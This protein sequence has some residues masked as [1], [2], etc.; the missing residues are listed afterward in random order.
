MPRPITFLP[1]RFEELES[2]HLLSLGPTALEQELLED[3]NRVRA[4]PQAELNYLFSSFDP[5]TAS[6]STVQRAIDYFDVHRST[7]LNQW[8]EL[9]P[10]PPLAWNSSLKLSALGHNEAMIGHD[11]QSH[12]VPGELGV[13]ERVEQTGYPLRSVAENVYAF[14]RSVAHAH[15]AFAIDWGDTATGIQSPP[16]HRLNM[17]SDRFQE[18]G[19]SI[20]S[21]RD[22]QTSLGPLIVT[23][24]FGARDDYRAQ[25]LGVVFDDRNQNGRYDAREGLPNVSV[26]VIGEGRVYQA[27][28]TTSGGYQLP[29]EPGR[30]TVSASGGGLGRTLSKTDVDVRGENVKVDFDR[31]TRLP[32]DSNGDG[33]FSFQDVIT[34]LQ[35][36]K[37]LTNLSAG[38]AEGD[39]NQ[40]GIFDQ[41]DV[42]VLLTAEYANRSLE[43]IPATSESENLAQDSTT[44]EMPV[45]SSISEVMVL[46]LQSG[47]YLTN[48]FATA[49]E[50]DANQDGRFDQRDLSI[51][52]QGIETVPLPT[53]STSKTAEITPPDTT[54][55][56]GRDTDHARG[57]AFT[58]GC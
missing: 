52:F 13:G 11:V 9:D 31:Q 51:F 46:L 28:T 33:E 47:K 19:I 2:R 39:W 45:T 6:D 41:R 16:A 1:G 8:R 43:P 18:I 3:L 15:A 56:E 10:S 20:I 4:N 7:L 26:E 14:A 25:L 38:Y 12:R 50:G 21:D 37:F 48:E 22:P 49:A 27:T 17:M 35:S 44:D 30:Y 29:V 53:V 5:L 42:I 32:G 54:I 40:D 24:N 57:H 23:E 55:S 34:V 36:A 58:W